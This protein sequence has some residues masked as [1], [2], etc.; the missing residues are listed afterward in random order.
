MIETHDLSRRFG[1]YDAVAGLELRI[2]AGEWYLLAGP[3]GAGKTTTMRLLMGILQPDRGHA[4]V[5][6]HDPATDPMAVRR[7]VGYLPERFFPYEHLSGREYLDFVGRAYGMSRAES[8]QRVDQVLELVDL[9]P[10]QADQLTKGYSFGM[11]KKIAFAAAIIHRPAVLLLDEP[12]AGTDPKGARRIY[13]VIA[14]F[15]RRGTTVLMSSHLLLEVQ[16]LCDTVGFIH[17]GRL[18]E[19]RPLSSLRSIGRSLPELFLDL[20]GHPDPASVDGFF[21][22]SHSPRGGMAPTAPSPQPLETLE[23]AMALELE[24]EQLQRRCDALR[25]EAAA[26]RAAGTPST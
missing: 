2:A 11:T 26:L 12:T 21:S 8:R 9:E 18:I 22:G 5:A 25:S 6:G 23:R 14:Q 7:A 4:L 16:E 24:A 17:R 13:D 3:N 20:L 1:D 10:S 15:V 19:T